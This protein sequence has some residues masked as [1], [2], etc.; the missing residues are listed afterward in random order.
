MSTDAQRGRVNFDASFDAFIAAGELRIPQSKDGK[1]MGLTARTALA[2]WDT[3]V[4]WVTASGKA[5]LYSYVIY[6]QQYDPDRPTPYNIATVELAEGPRLISVVI[7]DDLADLEVGMALTAEFDG[8]GRL[9][10]RPAE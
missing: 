2:G 7:I 10:F 8:D 6:H 5:T 4:N 9:V 1:I 3:D